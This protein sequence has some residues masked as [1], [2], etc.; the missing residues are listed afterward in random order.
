MFVITG[1]T[2]QVGGAVARGLLAE[3]QKL[4][5]VVRDTAK[6]AAWARQGCEV[7]VAGMEDASALTAA[8]AGAE[9]V[10]VLLP[11]NFAPSPGFP[12]TR[13]MIANLHAALLAARPDK[14]VCL[15]TIGAQVTRPNLLNQLGVMEQVL[16][17]LLM[18]VAF[19]RAAWFLE[20]AAW[21]VAPAREGIIPGFLQPLDRKLPMVATADIGR[22][23]ME[24]LRDN[25]SGRRVVELEGPVRVSPDDIAAAFATIL[26]RPVRMQA[27]PRQ[28]WEALFQ[29]QGTADPTARIQMLDGFNEGWIRFEGGEAI[30]AKGVVGLETVLRQLVDAAG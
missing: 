13:A 10:F 17:G 8:F 24:L 28:E 7:A 26:A 2:G 3:N 18:P 16:G 22:V 9:A 27:V 4:R 15:S 25:W 5:A 20:N 14:V 1:I 29:S 30:P 11:P 19:L 6:G 23:A 21:D 12:E